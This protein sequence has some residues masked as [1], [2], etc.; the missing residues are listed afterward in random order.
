MTREVIAG[1]LNGLNFVVERSGGSAGPTVVFLHSEMGAFGPAPVGEAFQADHDVVTLHLPGWGE[2]TGIEH[3]D[4]PAEFAV[5]LWWAIEQITSEP[6][7]LVGHGLGAALAA[8]MAIMQPKTVRGLVLS[9]PF[10]MFDE[11]YP[12]VDVFAL[13]PKDVMPHVYADPNGPI[14]AAHYPAPTDA[15]ERGLQAIRRV[16]VLGAASRFVFPLP[17][18]NIV[19]RAYRIAHLPMTVLFGERDGVVPSEMA[20]NWSKVFPAATVRTV[21]GTAHMTPYESNAVA[22]EV[23]AMVKSVVATA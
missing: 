5:A 21:A 18:T 11:A 3:F 8:E 19:K 1:P 23:S 13:M 4:N 6:V 9:N 14:M 17:D 7:V 15:Y 20:H 16:E 12:G 2:S 10:G 22:E